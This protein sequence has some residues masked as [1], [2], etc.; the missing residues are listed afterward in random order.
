MAQKTHCDLCNE[1]VARDRGHLWANALPEGDPLR[2]V[3]ATITFYG[4]PTNT[5]SRDTPIDVC[6]E[7]MTKWIRGIRGI[8]AE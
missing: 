4:A 2:N 8:L 7:C 5:R 1:V 3:S 6:N